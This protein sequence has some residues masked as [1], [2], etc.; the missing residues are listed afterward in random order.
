MKVLLLTDIPPCRNFTAGLVLD[1]LVG[2][3]PPE[4][5]ALCAVVNSALN[6][7]IPAEL[8]SL[9]KLILIKPREAS[10]RIFPRKAGDLSAFPFELIQSARVRYEL[11][12]QIVAFAKQQQ[13]DAVWVVLQG[14]TMVRLARQLSLK[15][16][17]PLFTQVWDPFGWWLRAN[18]I[19]GFSQRRLL[20]EFNK[21]IRHSASCATASW[22]MSETYSN[23]YGVRNQPVIAGLP[24][25]LAME[26]AT[27]PHAGDEFI[28]G[29]AGQ[30]YAQD[31][32]NCLIHTLNQVNWIIA[33]R[34]IRIRVMGGAFQMFT[35]SP[36]NFEYLGWQSQE[37]TI[38]LLSESDLLYMPYW[39]SE[40]FR[41]ESSSSFPSKL[42]TYFAAGRP[43]FCHAPAYASPAKYIKQ[44]EAGYLCETLDSSS[45][46]KHLESA[47]TDTEYYRKV[48]SNGTACF[49][50][51]F[52]LERM[53]E[54]FLKFLNIQATTQEGLV[55]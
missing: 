43:V 31:E 33:G 20:S 39:F 54:T 42:V 16:D 2:F 17:L 27:C 51:D 45:V 4:S 9:P 26:P 38:R 53:K 25:E 32:W 21:V 19:D 30:F 40:E 13:V 35:Q 1:R 11:L 10:V 5:I 14:Q 46:L 28:I 6:P 12:P 47:I 34:R 48:S 3:L 22:A 37:E 52:T 44:H 49:M 15:L 41:E 50:R 55:N 36:S 24:R 8:D 7:E 29:M 23:Q 18:R